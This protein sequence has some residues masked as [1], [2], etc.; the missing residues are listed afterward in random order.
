MDNLSEYVCRVLAQAVPPDGSA[1]LWGSLS[2]Y[3]K[4]GA[5]ALYVA[6][7][8]VVWWIVKGDL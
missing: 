6:V 5:F 4:L 7:W 8:S 1:T 3:E 2:N